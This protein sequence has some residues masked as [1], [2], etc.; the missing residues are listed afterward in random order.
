MKENEKAFDPL[1][2]KVEMVTIA[3]GTC[4]EVS[5][6]SLLLDTIVHLKEE[7]PTPAENSGRHT[8]LEEIKTPALPRN[9][10][11]AVLHSLQ[12]LMNLLTVQKI[13]HVSQTLKKEKLHSQQTHPV[14]LWYL[15]AIPFIS[16]RNG[17]PIAS[18]VPPP[19]IMER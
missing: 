1:I 14:T 9:D 11:A 5:A 8:V 6:P 17:K 15:L 4:I 18:I 12:Q 13:V 19:S 16:R 7:N 10:P 3:R 2:V